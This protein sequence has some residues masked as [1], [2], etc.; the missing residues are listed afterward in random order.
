MMPTSRT[1]AAVRKCHFAL[2]SLPHIIRVP[3]PGRP[4]DHVIRAVDESTLDD[5]AFAIIG[6][7]REFNAVADRLHALRKL[8]DLAREA[9][10]L[11]A[12]R[13]LEAIPAHKGA[14]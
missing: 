6:M 2:A 7:E 13:V 12:D 3:M 5:V 10:A 8:H 1:I 11:G 9:G 4:D 14:D